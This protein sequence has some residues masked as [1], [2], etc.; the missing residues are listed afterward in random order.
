M[1]PPPTVGE[2]VAKHS[3][4]TL[5][6]GPT[7]CGNRPVHRANLAFGEIRFIGCLPGQDTDLDTVRITTRCRSAFCP[8]RPNATGSPSSGLRGLRRG[9]NPVASPSGV[10]S[11]DDAARQ[12]QHPRGRDG[13]DAPF[14]YP[15]FG[16]VGWQGLFGPIFALGVI[17][18]GARAWLTGAARSLDHRRVRGPRRGLCPC[19]HGRGHPRGPRAAARRVRLLTPALRA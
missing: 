17:L 11:R 8:A 4:S 1:L 5:P 19:D 2:I 12:P 3:R 15:V 6:L 14:F 9:G 18:V 7:S 10:P 16:E 13:P